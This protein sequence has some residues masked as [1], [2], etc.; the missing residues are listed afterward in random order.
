[1]LLVKRGSLNNFDE[2]QPLARLNLPNSTAQGDSPQFVGA[3]HSSLLKG[4]AGNFKR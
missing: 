4:A 2:L 1:M 3:E